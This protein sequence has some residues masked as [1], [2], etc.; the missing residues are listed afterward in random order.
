MVT[1]ILVDIVGWIGATLILIAYAMI[2]TSRINGQS[3]AYQWMNAIGSIFMMVNAL[4][5]GALPSFG[6]NLIWLGIAIYGL[7]QIRFATKL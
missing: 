4:Y 2:T 3:L 6:L 5:Y 1:E 7:S